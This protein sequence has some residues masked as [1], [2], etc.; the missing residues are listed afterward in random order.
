MS[1]Q[2][3]LLGVV[4]GLVGAFAV[5]AQTTQGSLRWRGAG[6]A[7]LGLQWSAPDWRGPCS[8]VAFGCESDASTLLYASPKAPRSLSLQVS[9]PDATGGLRA[10]GATPPNLS[11]IGKAA[12]DTDL[13][14]G[15][16]GRFGTASR[17]GLLGNEGG[18]TYGVGLSW[19]FS[20]RGSAI[21]GWDSYDFRTAGGEG[22]DVRATSLGLRWRY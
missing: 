11:L 8:T 6:A 1:L 10:P 13:G 4:T 14:L 15:V 21:V 2:R 12:V 5:S 20:R 17:A 16:Y 19:D 7:P 9:Q 18:L 22:R 3:I